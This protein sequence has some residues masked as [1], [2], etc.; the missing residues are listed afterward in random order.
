MTG[1]DLFGVVARIR[2]FAQPVLDAASE[3]RP[4]D[5]RWP[6][7][8]PWRNRRETP[9][10]P[11]VPATSH[12]RPLRRFKP[13]PAYKD[14]GVE[15]LGEIPAHWEI[16]WIPELT[17]LLNGYQ[18][19]G[20]DV[21]LEALRDVVNPRRASVDEIVRV[22]DVCRI[23]TV[24]SPYLESVA[25]RKRPEGTSPRRSTRASSPVRKSPAPASTA[26]RRQARI[27]SWTIISHRLVDFQPQVG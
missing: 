18:K 14:S 17:T 22:A 21:A 5:H 13:Y 7:G 9:T 4:F 19:L 3:G 10:M 24:I 8:G 27:R 23:P 2:R 26:P 12:A 15:W 16:S 6:P 1:T 20:L 25:S 11:E